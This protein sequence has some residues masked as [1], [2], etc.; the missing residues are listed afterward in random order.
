MATDSA[1][2]RDHVVVRYSRRRYRLGQLWLGTNDGFQK[3]K[4]P[5]SDMSHS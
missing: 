3:E 2:S 1:V 5:L 4:L